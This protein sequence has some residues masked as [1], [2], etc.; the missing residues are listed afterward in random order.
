[1][2]RLNAQLDKNLGTT[3]EF[4]NQPRQLSNQERRL[5]VY[6]YSYV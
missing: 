4:S 3:S 2:A 5:Y 1:V 6:P